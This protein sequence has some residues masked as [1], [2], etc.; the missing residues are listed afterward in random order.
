MLI[1][2]T[3]R[4]ISA[5]HVRVGDEIA[6]RR[7]RPGDRPG[8]ADLDAARDWHLRPDDEWA[9][10]TGV[11]LGGAEGAYLYYGAGAAGPYR[12]LVHPDQVVIIRER[13]EIDPWSLPLTAEEAGLIDR[14]GPQ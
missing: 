13:I 14:Y 11:M 7:G 3:P 8:F 5:R 9:R 6:H 10:V 2:T 4:E 1:F 12:A